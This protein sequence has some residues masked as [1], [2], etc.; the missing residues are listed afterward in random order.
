MLYFIQSTSAYVSS[1]SL[2]ASYLW[3]SGGE[4]LGNLWVPD[5][6]TAMGFVKYLS[7]GKREGSRLMIIAPNLT[8]IYKL[9]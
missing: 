2:T 7:G 5:R 8:Q 3:A 4:W 9:V 1:R 6:D